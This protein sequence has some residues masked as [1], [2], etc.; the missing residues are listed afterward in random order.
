MQHTIAF[1]TKKV[2]HHLKHFLPSQS[3]L[4]D[5]VHHN[6]LHFFQDHS[7]SEA[8]KRSTKIFGYKTYLNIS[9]FR[10][11]Y[12]SGIIEEKIIENVILKHKSQEELEEYKFRLLY[13]NVEVSFQG[14]MGRIMHKWKDEYKV[15]ISK[16]I[17]PKLFRL[18]S[19]YLDQ[20]ISLIEFPIVEEGLLNNVRN[21][22][23]HSFQSYFLLK[24][25]RSRKWLLENNK[26]AL[27][28]PYLLKILVGDDEWFEDYLYDLCFEHPGW[29]G[30]VSVLEDH[31]DYLTHP[32]K[33]SLEEFIVLELLFQIDY[34]DYKLKEWQALT[35]V[36]KMPEDHLFEEKFSDEEELNFELLQ[37]WQ[38]AFEWSYYEKVL[39]A[40]KQH[41]S[42]INNTLCASQKS[43]QTIHCID[44]R[45][46]S[47]RRYLELLDNNCETFSTAGFFNIDAYYQ[48]QHSKH[49]LKI[50]PAPVKPQHLLKEKSELVEHTTDVHLEARHHTYLGGWLIAQTIGYWS[51]IKLALHL[52]KPHNNPLTIS[53]FNHISP[54][55]SIEYEYSPHHSIDSCQLKV[56]YTKEEA[57]QRSEL[58]LKSIGLTKN[59]APFVYIMAHG[60]GST[61]NPY[62]AAYDCGACSGKPGSVNARVMCAFLNQK[63]IREELKN[64]GIDIPNDTRFIPVLH[65][66]TTDEVLFYD[67]DDLN[68]QQKQDLKKHQEIFEKALHL[69]AKERARRFG[70]IVNMKNKSEEEIHNEVKN[71]QYA[72][73]EVRPE[74]NHATNALCVVGRRALT[75]DI[76]LDRRSFL[77]SYDYTTDKDGEL[78]PYVLKSITAVCGGINL[79]YYYSRVDNQKLGS[80]S[81]LPHNIFGLLSVANGAEGDLRI[82]LPSQMVEIHDPLRLLM[83]VEHYPQIVLNAIRFYPEVYEWYKNAWINLV[84]YHPETNEFYVFNTTLETM[85]KISDMNNKEINSITLSDLL[86]IFENNSQNLNV[87]FLK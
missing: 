13:D 33:I 71:R 73:F 11:L 66:T 45:E 20:G 50:A 36:S 82:G 29:S 86:K 43:F 35:K 12:R 52:F 25:G 47:F 81:K 85:E 75:K 58:L 62:Y 42:K 3:P 76:F 60:A 78:L 15:N 32:R 24:K 70:T 40:I 2:L 28:I 56:G 34:L 1:E 74:Y 61:N 17:Q 44:D 37:L 7:F 16:Y 68:E 49:L 57:V 22:E 69:N 51:A 39:N 31:P 23:L 79:E 30:M 19:N 83:I 80:G 48:P 53:A 38:E 26:E 55:S 9:E 5:F 84:V 72:L 8:N 6:L 65:N 14:R 18:I 77:Q 4:K 64:R 87:Y 10:Q 54:S 46:E 27:Q 21:I 67:T 59:F 41:S 63:E